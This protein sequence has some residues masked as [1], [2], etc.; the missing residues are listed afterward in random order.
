[1]RLIS[2]EV[3]ICV[4]VWGE[5]VG[6]KRIRTDILCLK[7]LTFWKIPLCTFKILIQALAVSRQKGLLSQVTF[8]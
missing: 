6:R 7:K 1:M 8:Y 2:K 5:R 4:F 3:V